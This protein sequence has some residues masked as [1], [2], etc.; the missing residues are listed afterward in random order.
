MILIHFPPGARGDFLAGLLLDCVEER[1]NFAVQ[2]PKS[3]YL[4]IHH[5]GT[6]YQFLNKIG[7]IKIRIDSNYDATNL[8]RI[9]RNHLSKNKK[10]IEVFLDD[11]IDYIYQYIKDILK[12]D[13]ECVL[14]KDKYD[15]WI[16]FNYLT[17]QNFL[18]QLYEK[19]NCTTPEPRLFSNAIENVQRQR[20]ELTDKYKRLAEILEF[21]IKM[22][23]LNQFRSFTVNDYT[24]SPDPKS[25]LTFRNYSK[26]QFTKE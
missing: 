15:Y 10:A 19:I 25:L 26:T 18:Y 6:N 2:T 4:K 16:D 13:A 7:C 22:N 20:D 8:I 21:E 1:D 11:E 9:A 24:N 23:L 3:A 17:D 14:H 12:L 5:T